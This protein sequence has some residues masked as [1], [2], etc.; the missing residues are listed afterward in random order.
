MVLAAKFSIL[1]PID[2]LMLTSLQNPLVKQIRKLH[3][4]KQ[5]QL[6][7]QFLLEGTH[8]LQEALAV[9]WP[10]EV[11]C[12]TSDWLAKQPPKILPQLQQIPRVEVVSPEVLAAMA[13]TTSPDGVIAMARYCAPI[14]PPL[15]SLGVVLETIQD[16]GNLGTIF[17][18][19]AAA[20]ADAVC[21]SADCVDPYSPKVL[22]ASAGLG[23]RLPVVTWPDLPTQLR[24]YRDQGWQ[25]LATLPQASQ[26]YW[27]VDLRRP[28]LILLG[29]E[30]AGLS[31]EL[32]GIAQTEIKIPLAPGVESLNV[33][34]ASALILYEAQRQRQQS[35]GYS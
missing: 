26:T 16:P 17:R 25:L 5:R 2:S 24:F 35:Q 20:N 6:H 21:L 8:L 31:A 11:V 13:T 27:Q 30:G 29:N 23:L 28:S 14:H 34:V 15:H 7:Q 4:T 3:Q 32:V 10:L 18:T 33:A 22:R 9:G 1:I 19:A 12:H